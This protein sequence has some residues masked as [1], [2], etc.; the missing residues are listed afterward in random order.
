MLV[1]T[2]KRNIEGAPLADASPVP[3]RAVHTGGAARVLRPPASPLLRPGDPLVGPRRSAAGQRGWL[4]GS[5]RRRALLAKYFDHLEV[6]CR[7]RL[8]VQQR[9]LV[10]AESRVQAH[11]VRERWL[12]L[13]R[14]VQFAVTVYHLEQGWQNCGFSQVQGRLAE[15]LANKTAHAAVLVA[16]GRRR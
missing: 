6:Q 9:R 15:Q 8:V 10:V 11:D 2:R 1:L 16:D 3:G 7:V 5:L 12:L 13:A 14:C 4:G